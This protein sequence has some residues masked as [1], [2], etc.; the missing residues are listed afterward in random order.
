VLVETNNPKLDWAGQE[1]DPDPRCEYCNLSLMERFDG[2]PPQECPS[3][4]SDFKRLARS[5]KITD[6]EGNV[7][8][9]S[10]NEDL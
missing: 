5:G 2:L 3:C 7:L 10:F 1:F 9:F 8:R 4:E 6:Q